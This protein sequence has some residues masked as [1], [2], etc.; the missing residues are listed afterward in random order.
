MQKYPLIKRGIFYHITLHTR[1]MCTKINLF[2]F[3]AF[4]A[5][6]YMAIYHISSGKSSGKVTTVLPTL[7]Y[8]YSLSR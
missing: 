2:I 7:L 6:D 5:L 8:T 4:G 3:I 1:Q